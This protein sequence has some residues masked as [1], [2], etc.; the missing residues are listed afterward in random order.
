M[1]CNM[2]KILLPQMDIIEF[3]DL[4]YSKYKRYWYPT[5]DKD[6]RYS[7]ILNH[8]QNW[9]VLLK[10]ISTTA[11]GVALDLGAGEGTDAIK[12]ALLG[13]EVD[14]LEG[15]AVGAEKIN[16]FSR[17]IGVKV[18]VIHMNASD[19]KPARMYDVVICN[20]LLHYIED[21]QLILQKIQCATSKNGCCLV[22]LFSDFTPVPDCHQIVNVYPD[23]EKGVVQSF[24]DQWKVLY[25]QLQ[26][27]RLD[28]SHLGFP[29]H[30]HSFIKIVAKK[31]E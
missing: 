28:A 13:Y 8:S 23:S 31:T 10:Q 4:M 11:P 27:N 22:S 20:G 6:E 5:L 18:N 2:D 17:K 25:F 14:A 19:F 7:V 1:K 9:E 12:L 29:I 3:F 30:Q 16:D 21:K 24:F 26:R 15:S